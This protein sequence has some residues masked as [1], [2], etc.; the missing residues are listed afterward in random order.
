[1]GLGR[2][3][4]GI[5]ML[6]AELELARGDPAKHISRSPLHIFPARNVVS[7][8]RSGYEQRSFLRNLDQIEWQYGSA[9]TS[10]EHHITTGPQDVESLF[11]RSLTHR[12]VHN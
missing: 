2:I 11:E 8:R 7:Q 3:F 5:S 6:D 10:E 12:V 1:M 9:G 4:Q